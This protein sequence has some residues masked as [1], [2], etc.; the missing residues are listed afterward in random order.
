MAGQSKDIGI[1]D[2]KLDGGQLIGGPL[3]GP[4][5]EGKRLMTPMQASGDYTGPGNPHT[6]LRGTSSEQSQRSKSSPRNPRM[7]D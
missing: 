2:A 5:R 1:G 3:G 7:A 4:G 6:P